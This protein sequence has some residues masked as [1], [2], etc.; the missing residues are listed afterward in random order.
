MPSIGPLVRLA[1]RYGPIVYTQGQKAYHRVEPQVRA[2]LLAQQVDGYVVE[3]PASDGTYVFVLDARGRKVVDSFP[4]PAPH[5]H[6][7]VL[8][9]DADRRIHHLDHWLH[10]VTDRA[11]AAGETVR[12]LGPGPSS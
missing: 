5:L 4:H 2:Y 6:A 9:A 3:W 12:R 1:T 8:A 11:K 10:R 7:A